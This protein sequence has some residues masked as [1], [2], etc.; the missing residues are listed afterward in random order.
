MTPESQFT[1]VESPIRLAGDI[2]IALQA[3][4]TATAD[5]LIQNNT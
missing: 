4:A 5:T 2:K 1:M 3:T